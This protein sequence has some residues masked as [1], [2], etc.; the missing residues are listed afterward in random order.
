MKIRQEGCAVFW[1]LS[2]SDL[3]LLCWHI[4]AL[5]AS[6]PRGNSRSRWLWCV[7]HVVW[8]LQ[9]V[10]YEAGR[11]GGY[12]N[13]HVLTLFQCHVL[14]MSLC[15]FFSVLCLPKGN[16]IPPVF[17]PLC[18]SR[19]T[20]QYPTPS[21]TASTGRSRSPSNRPTSPSTTTYRRIPGSWRRWLKYYKNNVLSLPYSLHC[22]TCI[23]PLGA[24]S[25]FFPLLH[26]FSKWRFW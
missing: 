6:A 25:S 20:S 24:P 15:D 16:E 12:L 3:F 10:S 9:N 18:S 22:L 4:S 5:G 2:A 8:L 17:L 14:N 21:P 19:P 13:Q 11:S 1:S 23:Y 7:R 26:H